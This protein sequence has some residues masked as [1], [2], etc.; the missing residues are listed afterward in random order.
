MRMRSR[1][2][3]A[4]GLSILAAGVFA[5]GAAVRGS[6]GSGVTIAAEPLLA[7]AGGR[8][9]RHPPGFVHSA[10]SAFSVAPGL[11][12]TNAHVTLR[13]AGAP[14][15]VA[16]HAGPWHVVREDRVLDLVLLRGPQDPAIPALRL[17]A[18]SRLAPG[19]P[20]FV[21]GYPMN[22]ALRQTAGPFAVLGSVRQMALIL[23]Q[24][25]SGID[26]SFRM[27]ATDGTSV[28]PTWR[29]GV[30]FFG[31]AQ[32]ERMRWALEVAVT[33]TRGASGGPVVDRS[34][35]VIGVVVANG[36][37]PGLTSAITLPDLTEFLAAGAV[38]P[39]F[40]PARDDSATDWEN[41]YRIVAPSV[42][43]VGC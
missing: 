40:A 25:E 19:A 26:T 33:L 10:G 6:T 27:T 41:T 9:D 15:S 21:V 36:T 24:P 42:V 1:L 12:V 34:G 3:W 14:V 17:S 29:D 11:L 22:P 37:Q 30:A 7:N 35:S 31:P 16:D 13:C 4:A 43:R 5:M 2:Q 23:H 20:A 18:S 28:D 39:S 38:I 8:S 32:A